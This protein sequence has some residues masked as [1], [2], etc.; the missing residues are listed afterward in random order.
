[1]ARPITAPRLN[2]NPSGA[3]QMLG[4]R[5]GFRLQADEWTSTIL[6]ELRNSL[7]RQR[8]SDIGAGIPRR[9][10]SPMLTRR[11]TDTMSLG[12]RPAN[13]ANLNIPLSD[14]LEQETIFTHR[15]GVP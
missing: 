8:P 1:M 15:S 11:R 4:R 9:A 13:R 14:L 12:G 7:G 6:P 5:N 10:A 3:N 2:A